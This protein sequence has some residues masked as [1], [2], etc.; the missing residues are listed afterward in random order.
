[1]NLIL[2]AI[3]LVYLGVL[4][5]ELLVGPEK[6]IHTLYIDVSGWCVVLLTISTIIDILMERIM[7]GPVAVM[8]FL[9]ALLITLIFDSVSNVELSWYKEVATARQK[10]QFSFVVYFIGLQAAL[11]LAIYLEHLHPL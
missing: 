4:A 2:I 5:R 9:T 7:F 1:M 10:I 3:I 8:M 6:T 11:W